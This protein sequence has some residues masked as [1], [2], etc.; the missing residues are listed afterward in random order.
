MENFKDLDHFQSHDEDLTSYN[1]KYLVKYILLKDILST[2]R[3]DNT[4]FPG[5]DGVCDGPSVLQHEDKLGA[6]KQG[7]VQVDRRARRLN[8]SLLHRRY[9][10][11]PWRA[12]ISRVKAATA[13]SRTEIE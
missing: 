10:G 11:S 4:Y 5:Y 6:G 3:N 9:A 8:G 7:A 12:M 1:N 2:V 13:L